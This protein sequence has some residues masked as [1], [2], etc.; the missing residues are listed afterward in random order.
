MANAGIAVESESLHPRHLDRRANHYLPSQNSHPA[1]DE[2]AERA[3]ALLRRMGANKP[4]YKPQYWETVKM[5]DQNA[6]EEDPAND[7]MPAGVPRAGTTPSS[8]ARCRRT[9]SSSTRGKA[10]LIATQTSY[11][12]VPD[13]WAQAYAAGRS[14]PIWSGG[15]GHWEGDTMVMD[16]YRFQ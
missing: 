15:I 2:Q 4:I 16:T 14:G 6:N 5:L 13:G 1:D 11:R 9:S 8:L 12:V 10:A 3:A 7:C